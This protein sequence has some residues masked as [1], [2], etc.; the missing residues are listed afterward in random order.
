MVSYGDSGKS[1]LF[2]NLVGLLLAS[3]SCIAIL[4][5]SLVGS[6]EPR[7]GSFQASTIV[8]ICISVGALIFIGVVA[9]VYFARLIRDA[10]TFKRKASAEIAELRD[11]LQVADGI[12]EAEP[13]TIITWTPGERGQVLIAALSGLSGVPVHPTELLNFR[14]W[15]DPQSYTS[16]EPAMQALF[17]SGTAF[18][19]ISQTRQGGNLELDGRHHG[20]RAILKI[21]DVAGHRDALTKILDKHRAY[22]R[23]IAANRALIDALPTPVW[24]RAENG[25]LTWANQAYLKSVGLETL[26]E[27][28]AEQIELLESRQRAAV[29]A[30]LARRTTFRQ[31][32][33]LIVAGERRAYD[34]LVVPLGAA[35]AGM[36]IDVAA[37]ESAEGKLTRQTAAY[38]R[39]L[40]KVATAVATFSSD[41]RLVFFNE[42]YRQFWGFEETW[43]ASKPSD[44]EI[45]DRLRERRMIPVE[46]DHRAWK[47]K[48]MQSYTNKDSYED[49]WHLPDGRTV[50]VVGEPLPDGGITYLYDDVTERFALE[51]R[52]NALI[53]VQRETLDHL[54]E[55]VALFATDGRL[56]LFNPSFAR[57]WQLDPDFLTNE[58]HI[59]D[60]TKRSKPLFDE[61]GTWERIKASITAISDHRDTIS[62]T[63]NR[64]DG[65]VVEY[66]G[67]PLP[68][69][70]TLFTYVDTTDTKRMERAL[71]ERN[72]ALQASERLKNTF[73]SHVSYNLRTPLTNIIGFSE[74]LGSHISGELNEKQSD[75]LDDIT[76]SSGILL[77]IINDILDLTSIDAGALELNVSRTSTSDIIEGA[78]SAL[79]ERLTDHGISLTVNISADAQEFVADK[80]RL[81]QVL[82]NLLSNSIGFSKSG[83]VIDVRARRDGES[84]VISV[85]DEGLGIPDEDQ[86]NVFDRFESQ[87]RG[88]KHRGVGLGLSVAKALVELHGGTIA[89][90]SEQNKGSTVELR[91]PRHGVERIAD[92]E[93]FEQLST[94]SQTAAA[95]AKSA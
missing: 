48:L 37:I 56:K 64:P 36:A 8:V 27:L 32:Q 28:R 16:F 13:Q 1:E 19:L 49:W 75:Y 38:D 17:A 92:F 66:A 18:N 78:R 58:P 10:N 50:H 6:S 79:Q 69:G 65:T 35:S 29:S 95:F 70:A 74:L 41:Q 61:P 60:I 47:S 94:E 51:S 42:V 68:D 54:N 4:T 91:L 81:E 31:R 34:V 45:L 63:M 93:E 3:L 44:G 20:G 82:E 84:I 22:S 11:R 83:D 33:H 90:K 9:Y 55:G 89:L 59:E 30:T 43:L 72:E 26:D 24:F 12:I 21:R 23:D 53:R 73:I 46:V 67:L 85:S 62:G 52:Y 7:L 39:T 76:N 86:Q 71:I 5:V 25:D 80:A 88:S 14:N 87:S 2:R 40:D 77:S 15:L 57:I